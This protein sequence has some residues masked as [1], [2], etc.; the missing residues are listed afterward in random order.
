MSA[1]TDSLLHI[2]LDIGSTTVKLII[3]DGER[4][5]LFKEYVR[6]RSDIKESLIALLEKAF[7]LFGD[8]SVTVKA[9]G[10]AGGTRTRWPRP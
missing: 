7:G 1:E 5:I 4:K 10:S 9:A 8:R 2:G 3:I 6:H